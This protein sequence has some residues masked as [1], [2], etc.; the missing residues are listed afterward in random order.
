MNH[1]N[2]DVFCIIC[3]SAGVAGPDDDDSLQDLLNKYHP[4]F[5]MSC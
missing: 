4:S 2:F 5:Y 3:N 1:G